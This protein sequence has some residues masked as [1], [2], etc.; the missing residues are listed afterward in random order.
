MM[1]PIPTLKVNR[2]LSIMLTGNV[3]PCRMGGMPKSAANEG[4]EDT[5]CLNPN[6]SCSTGIRLMGCMC[7]HWHHV[8]GRPVPS[9]A[10][11]IMG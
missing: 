9:T 2:T 4:S 8:P 1:A 5:R 7:I 3:M 6:W 11:V 10:L